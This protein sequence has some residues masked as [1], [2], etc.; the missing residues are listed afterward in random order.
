MSAR[1]DTKLCYS[2]WRASSSKRWAIT[3]KQDERD[4]KNMQEPEGMG[5]VENRLAPGGEEN[6]GLKGD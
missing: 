5:Y 3:Y 2:T 4:T 6:L 1:V